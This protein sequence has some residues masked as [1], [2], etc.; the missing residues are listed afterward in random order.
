MLRLGSVMFNG[1]ATDLTR[2]DFIHLLA[3]F[4]IGAAGTV[5]SARV[6]S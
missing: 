6:A 1:P 2:S 3:G 5:G 4:P